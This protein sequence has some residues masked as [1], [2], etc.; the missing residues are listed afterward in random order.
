M[1]KAARWAWQIRCAAIPGGWEA[2]RRLGWSTGGRQAAVRE[3]PQRAV[4][5]GEGRRQGSVPAPFPKARWWVR[6]GFGPDWKSVRGSATVP[7]YG[8]LP[9]VA[10]QAARLWRGARWGEAQV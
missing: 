7:D 9:L 2:F 8:Q 3:A 6:R 1:V 5:A 4:S 10:E